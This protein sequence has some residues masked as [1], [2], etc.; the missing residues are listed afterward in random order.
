[1]SAT[2][3]PPDPDADPSPDDGEPAAG[4]RRTKVAAG[5]GVGLL[6]VV[7]VAV[8]VSTGGGHKAATAAPEPTP[9]PTHSSAP[10]S[11]S[12]SAPD[13]P[14][15]PDPQTF[16]YIDLHAGDCFTSSDAPIGSSRLA[17]VGC[18]RAHEAEVTGLVQLPAGLTTDLAVQQHATGLCGPIDRP[19]YDR[20]SSLLLDETALFPDLASYRGGRHTATCALES[21]DPGNRLAAPLR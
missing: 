14:P 7:A 2:P 17:K 13:T 20:N 16:D 1:M 10:A 12:P 8:A 11:P 9:R 6:V 3:T 21:D 18:D 19:V 4:A 15:V 5:V